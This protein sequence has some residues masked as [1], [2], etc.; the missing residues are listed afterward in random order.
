MQGR[1]E[2]FWQRCNDAR[3]AGRPDGSVAVRP[4]GGM[5]VERTWYAAD[6]TGFY[7]LH[8]LF[9]TALKYTNL[10]RYDEHF[11]VQL[12]VH[13]GRCQG[14]AALD[15]RTGEVFPVLAP[16]VILCTGGAGRIYAFT[17]NAVAKTGDG[18]AL[19]YR[20]GCR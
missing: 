10:V 16:A 19:A 1:E 14:V 15:F 3:G 18:M 7:M 9:Q 4:F 6:K 8:T 13:E 20:A 11:A 5:K 12:L 17:T 2:F